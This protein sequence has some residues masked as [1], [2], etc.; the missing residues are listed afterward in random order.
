MKNKEKIIRYCIIT[1]LIIG[2]M[3]CITV[4]F[5]QVRQKIIRLGERILHRETSLYEEWFRVLLSYAMGG[6]VFIFLS[7]YCLL[8]EHG[9]ALVCKVKNEIRDC[10]AEINW[11]S[12]IKPVLLMFGVYLLGIL[13]IIRANF[14][15]MDDIFRSIS[16]FRGWYSWSRYVSEYSSIFIHGDYHLTN[17]SPLPQLFAVFFLTISS[18]LLVYV[19][20]NRKI[21]II[22]LLASI[23]LGLS[24]YMLEC[25]SYQFDSPYMAFSVLA[26]IVPFLFLARKRAFVFFSVI[27]LLVMCMTY[28]AA[29][30]IYLLVTLLLCFNDWNEK[31]KTN[32]EVFLFLGQAALSFGIAMA[33]FK[34]FIMKPLNIY[35]SNTMAPLPQL[36]PTVLTNI[37]TYASVINSDFGFIWKVLI[38][39]ILGFFIVKSVFI[40][41]QNKIFLF[42]ISF[43]LLSLLFA[44]SNGIFLV[45][46]HP[47]FSPRTMYGLGAFLA[48][49]GIYIATN[50]NK[51]AKIAT[52]ALSWSFFV[53]VFSYGN[54]LADQLRYAN[55]RITILLHDLS[56]LYPDKDENKITIQLENTIGFTPLVKNTAKHNP[57]IYTLVPD[58]LMKYGLLSNIYFM[59]YFNYSSFETANILWIYRD[60]KPP[61]DFNTLDLPIVLKTYYHTIRSDGRHVLVEL[62]EGVK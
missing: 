36:F 53:F 32:R 31:R 24:P 22:A 58:L 46:A 26:S 30:G 23:P 3:A 1:V 28:Q 21:T 50:F 56:A 17:I 40:S 5:P 44:L 11:R 29:S 33:I 25:L 14:L 43:I 38:G 4:L 39:V 42:F 37:Q 20:N 34:L 18:V 59:Q 2:L 27:S 35:V 62:N 6:I 61:V 60:G 51:M 49:I 7:G 54:A 9:K 52:L 57:I 19:L 48:I 13:S 47:L 15:Y 41:A 12:F 10:L 8:T 55:F 16:G 45:L